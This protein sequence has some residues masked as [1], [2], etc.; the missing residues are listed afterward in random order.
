MSRTHVIRI[1]T[2]LLIAYDPDKL[3]D[4]GRAEA[5]CK[6][7]EELL[8]ADPALAIEEWAVKKTTVKDVE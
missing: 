4:T 3:G 2:T 1:Q 7:V 8:S 6:R 5:E